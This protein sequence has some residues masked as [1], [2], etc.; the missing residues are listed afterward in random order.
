[1]MSFNARQAAT[2]GSVQRGQLVRA[3]NAQFCSFTLETHPLNQRERNRSS[4]D[5]QI[6]QLH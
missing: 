1:M 6:K 2:V 5:F 4:W 3:D